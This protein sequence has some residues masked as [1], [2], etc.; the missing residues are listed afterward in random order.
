MSV[1]RS[2]LSSK[3]ARNYQDRKMAKWMG[4]FLSEHSTSLSQPQTQDALF[5]EKLSSQERLL[6]L[7]Q[8]YLQ[9]LTVTITYL[10]GKKYP[11]PQSFTGLIQLFDLDKCH[12][13]C[14]KSQS[15]QIIDCNRILTITLEEVD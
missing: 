12:L 10:K 2:Y 5:Q 14:S 6:L 7:N 1:D 4:F 11:Q 8:A 15:Y 9:K 3:L 13:Y